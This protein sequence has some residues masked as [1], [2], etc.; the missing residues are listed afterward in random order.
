MKERAEMRKNIL[1]I[2][3]FIFT[4]SGCS[5]SK[6]E[7]NADAT[8]YF[9]PVINELKL[10]SGEMIPIMDAW[11]DEG[12]PY[13]EEYSNKIYTCHIGENTFTFDLAE[14]LVNGEQWYWKTA[15]IFYNEAE[16]RIYIC[17][18]DY[19]V[20]YEDHRV[21]EPQLLIIEF[22]GEQPQKYEVWSYTVEP[23]YLFGWDVICYR[24]Q[25][26]VFIVGENELAVIDLDSMHLRYCKEEYST[27]EKCIEKEFGE[28]PYHMFLFRAVL[29]QDGMTV[30]SAEIAE[31]IDMPPIA[32]IY[33][34]YRE[35]NL[36]AYMIVD[37]STDNMIDYKI[38]SL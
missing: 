13:S 2:L 12:V 25:D 7:N 22:S 14:E 23:P 17:L 31:A 38:I 24:M 18:H 26:N 5:A 16:D 15:G 6:D 4:L 3:V 10:S 36:I 27:V 11:W 34:A 29:E 33:A 1:L 19:N 21:Q 32:M 8:D 28:E 37:L 9:V 35:N 20:L 30:Y